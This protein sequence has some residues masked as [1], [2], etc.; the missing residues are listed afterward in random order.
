MHAPDD[1][2]KSIRLKEFEDSL[3]SL[4]ILQISCCFLICCWCSG[5]RF[6]NGTAVSYQLQQG[7]RGQDATI[8]QIE[9]ASTA[10]APDPAAGRASQ[11]RSKGIRNE[12]QNGS[13]PAQATKARANNFAPPATIPKI[14]GARSRPPNAVSIIPGPF[15]RQLKF[16]IESFALSFQLCAFRFYLPCKHC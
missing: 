10:T 9:P 14:S 6:S 15:L 13:L 4:I 8:Q 2:I 16:C 5:L 12:Q 3:K 7:D 1:L 11:V